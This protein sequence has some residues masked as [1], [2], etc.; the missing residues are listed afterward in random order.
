VHHWGGADLQHAGRIPDATAVESHSDHWV[1]ARRPATVG[2]GRQHEGTVR[3]GGLLAALVWL[4]GLGVAAFDALSA[5]AIGARHGY[6]SHGQCL[7]RVEPLW[8]TSQ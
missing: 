1:F 5:V 8:H 4:A 3:T 2:S 7:S 6:E